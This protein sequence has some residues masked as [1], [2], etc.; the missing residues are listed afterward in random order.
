MTDLLVPIR[1]RRQ[2]K[3]ILTLKNFGR[4][5]IAIAV[6]FAGL[7]LRSELRHGNG[8]GYGRLFGKQVA[9]QHEIAKPQFDVVKEVPVADQSK[10]DALLEEAAAR[11]QYLIDD[12]AT[13]TVATATQNSVSEPAP[14][15][16]VR[17][18]AAGATIVGDSNGVSVV[19]AGDRQRPV[20]SGGIFRPQQ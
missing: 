3:R 9:G 6:V 15:P 8:N 10:P 14:A 12:T 20:L 17:G 2:R 19:R 4:F 13:T 5:A 11:S 7:T 1:D 18:S 16:V